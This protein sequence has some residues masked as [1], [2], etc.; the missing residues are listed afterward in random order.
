MSVPSSICFVHFYAHSHV[1]K[2]TFRE[3]DQN[4]GSLETIMLI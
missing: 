3:L 2:Q 4:H 1:H